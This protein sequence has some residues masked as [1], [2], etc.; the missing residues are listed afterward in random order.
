M[1]LTNRVAIVTGGS[2][3]LGRAIAERFAQAGARLVLNSRTEKELRQVISSIEER[4]GK[5]VGVPGDLSEEETVGRILYTAEKEFGPVDILVNNAG[6]HGG[7]PLLV[8]VSPAD[9]DRLMAV[10]LRAPFLLMRAVLPGMMERGRGVILNISSV[11]AKG[12]FARTG[13]YAASKAG[14]IALTRAAA[15]EAGQRGVRVNAL[16]PGIMEGSGQ[17]QE[18][19]EGMAG[20]MKISEEQ[21]SAQVKAGILLGR[22]VV[23]EEIA[24]VALF[25]CSDEASAITGQAVNADCGFV[26]Q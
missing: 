21:L 11:A 14:L 7:I 20:L 19:R 22:L 3:S 10:N 1:R 17:W 15:A 2:R 24:G 23:P 4:G 25:L 18:V 16:C 5:A 12:A 6:I 13:A 8:E 26:F 9:W